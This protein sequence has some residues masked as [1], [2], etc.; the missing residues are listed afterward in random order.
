MLMLKQ[1]KYSEKHNKQ[2]DKDLHTYYNSEK[3]QELYHENVSKIFGNNDFYRN[4]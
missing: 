4:V 2:I 3:I 1:G